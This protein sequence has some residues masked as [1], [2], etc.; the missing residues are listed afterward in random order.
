MQEWKRKSLFP[1]LV[2]SRGQG[3][4]YFE[5]ISNSSQGGGGGGGNLHILINIIK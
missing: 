4:N 5:K 1:S 3:G 2:D